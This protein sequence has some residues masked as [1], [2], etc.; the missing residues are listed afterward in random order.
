M[1]N[2]RRTSERVKLYIPV[3]LVSLSCVQCMLVEQK[4]EIASKEADGP[5][6]NYT[7]G[8]V[9][10]LAHLTLDE[11]IELEKNTWHWF[12][13]QRISYTQLEDGRNVEMFCDEGSAMDELPDDIFTQEQRLQGA[14]VL[15]FVCAI[16]FFVFLA[17]VV[18]EYFL[19]TVE[20]ICEDLK[21]TQD[22]AAATFM[23]IAGT[24]PEFFTNTISTFIADSD[25]G[26]GT[27]MGSLLFNTLGV[28]GIAGLASKT[29]VQMDWWPLTRDSLVFAIH[30]G[31]LI[32]FAWDGRIYW[33]ESMVLFILLFFYFLIMFQN[34]RIMKFAKKYIEVKWN[35][36]ARVIREIEETE[37]MEAA[38][39]AEQ[40][41]GTDKP[42]TS[43][44]QR[45]IDKPVFR[46][47]TASML[48]DQMAEK[49][50]KV[51]ELQIPSRHTLPDPDEHPDMTLW[52]ISRENW[53]RTIWWFF[54][55]PIRFILTFT[56]P[57]PVQFRRWYPFAFIMCIIYIGACSF[58]IFWMMTII[59]YTF[60]I[61]DSVMGL[62]FLAMGGCMPEAI[63]A[64]LVIRTGNGAMGV[65]NALGANSLSILFSLGLPWFIRNLADGG[66]ELNAY[67][68]IASYG[69][70]YSI[71]SLLFA[72]GALYIIVYTAKF[73]LRKT[74]GLALF[75]V[76]GIL[77]AFM[78]L[79]ELDVFFASGNE[80]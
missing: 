24:T 73:K 56:V 55:W 31:I 74:V 29:P 25:M 21:L 40:A 9:T 57:H 42:I 16:Y 52:K 1:R 14:I 22:V 46:L 43:V 50:L 28:A 45:A 44:A 60:G 72:I 19:P 33:Y 17:Y 12:P 30:V 80:C 70:Q 5:L 71:I 3:L 10:H 59:G 27:I 23:A 54:S 69:M 35:L 18:G 15:H 49:P 61:P 4:S 20:C 51:G 32:G 75:I 13:Y 63:A 36:C 34:R 38:A 67:L 79:N 58:V 62:T 37:R 26:I 48:S 6:K 7:F 68:P 47:S 39:Q 8:S 65:S 78:L 11:R 77:V 64:V 76:Y 53:F 66:S 41:N 2:F